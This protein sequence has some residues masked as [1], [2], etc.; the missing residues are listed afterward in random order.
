M[1]ISRRKALKA[2]GAA[3]AGLSLGAVNP[4]EAL[5]GVQ[6]SQAEG[7]TDANLRNLADLPLNADGSAVQFSPQEA[8]SIQGRV[9]WRYTSGETPDIEFDYNKMKINV[10]TRGTALRTGTMTF[11]DLEKLP[12]HSEVVKLQCGSPEPS[13]IVKWTGVKFSDFASMMGIQSTAHYCRIV[14][15]DNYYVEED[16][17]T[18]M[19]PQV[20]LAW[21]MNDGPI[22]PEHGAPLRFV[23]PFRWAG[24]S[25]KGITDI[26]FTATSF[27]HPEPT[28]NQG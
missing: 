6:A 21:K 13:G 12:E 14:G 26:L 20:M 28:S 11:A 9:I 5:A 18:M 3:L 23:I 17:K 19:H 27:P 24:R 8:G 4:A 15:S 1:E 25:V 22:P 7:L 2:S 16:M 10:A